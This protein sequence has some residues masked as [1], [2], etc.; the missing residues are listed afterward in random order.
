MWVFGCVAHGQTE[1]P[2][3]AWIIFDFASR[4]KCTLQKEGR[5]PRARQKK[6]NQKME[7]GQKLRREIEFT[8]LPLNSGVDTYL[9]DVGCGFVWDVG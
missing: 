6:M 2:S 7:M 3:I 4:A 5:T 8:S 9:W 1:L